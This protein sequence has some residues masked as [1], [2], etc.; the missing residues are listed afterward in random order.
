[1]TQARLH[2]LPMRSSETE[3]LLVRATSVGVS[4]NHRGVESQVGLRTK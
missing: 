3:L 4:H 2:C 1:M